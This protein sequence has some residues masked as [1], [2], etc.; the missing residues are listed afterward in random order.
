MDFPK[1][2]LAP[3][4]LLCLVCFYGLL[5]SSLLSSSTV[6]SESISWFSRGR[7]RYQNG[8]LISEQTSQLEAGLDLNREWWLHSHCMLPSIIAFCHSAFLTSVRWDAC[9]LSADFGLAFSVRPWI[10]PAPL[11]CLSAQPEEPQKKLVHACNLS[12]LLNC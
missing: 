5:V 3:S 9:F 4:W 12:L 2:K 6:P 7:S 1:T 10:P 11:L 8:S